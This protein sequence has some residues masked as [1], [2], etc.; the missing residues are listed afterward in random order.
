MILCIEA[1]IVE[2]RLV[3]FEEEEEEDFLNGHVS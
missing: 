2:Y 3:V 1:L